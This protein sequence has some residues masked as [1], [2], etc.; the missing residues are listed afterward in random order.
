MNLLKRENW[1]ACLFLTILSE[2]LFIF[3]MGYFMKAYDKNAWYT[4]WQYWVFG[5]IFFI[6]PAIIMLA[7][8]L[9]EINCKIANMLLVPGKSIYYNPYTWIIC[10]IVPIVGWVF[11]IVMSLYIMIWPNIMLKEGNGEKFI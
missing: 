11:L 7:V 2:G 10:L 8:F 4:K 5:T 9:I 3:V 6:F 1:L